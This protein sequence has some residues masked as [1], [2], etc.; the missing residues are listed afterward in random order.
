MKLS[1][2][3]A[4]TILAITTTALVGGLALA[5]GPTIQDVPWAFKGGLAIG[6][7][8]TYDTASNRISKRLGKSATIDFTSAYSG[9]QLSPS[10]TVTGAI[11]GDMCTVGV[12]T[13]ATALKAKWGCVVDAADS[14]KVWFSP[15][16]T[17][18]NQLTFVSGTP[19]TVTATVSAS[20]ICVCTPLGTTKTIAAGGCAWSVSST[21]AT[22]T[23]P[24]TVTTPIAAHCVAPV[25]PASGTFFVNVTRNG[26]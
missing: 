22:F 13:A 19:S 10:I 23:G 20:S 1:R 2:L 24:D 18:D 5:A 8:S 7:G 21:T 14:V 16:D 9:V 15:E 11:A 25:D 12:P 6:S 3:S 17:Y 4:V 26:S